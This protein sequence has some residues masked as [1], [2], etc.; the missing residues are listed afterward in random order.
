MAT[1]ST[2][3]PRRLVRCFLAASAATVL[4][5]AG[6]DR[7]DPLADVVEEA[8]VTLAALSGNGVSMPPAEVRTQ[9]YNRVITDLRDAL[10]QSGD[11]PGAGAARLIIAQAM[12]GQGDVAA[13]RS[14][15][16]RRDVE[17]TLT[18]ARSRLSLRLDRQVLGES[19]REY[20]P[21]QDLGRLDQAGE[22]TERE[23]TT[24]RASLQDRQNRVASLQEQ[25]DAELDAASGFREQEI[26]IREEARN[27]SP[28]Q[29]ARLIERAV[30]VKRNA[31]AHDRRAAELDLVVQSLEN[32]SAEIRIDI[33]SLLQQQQMN[34]EA[35]ERI[36]GASTLFERESSAAVTDAQNLASEIGGVFDAMIEALNTEV[37]PAFDEATGKYASA[38]SEAQQAASALS[39][40]NAAAAV[41]AM[42]RH[43]SA[44]LHRAHAATLGAL[45]S[46]ARKL[47]ESF[48]AGRF[49]DAAETLARERAE[50]EDQ[51][52]TL[53][54]TAASG[55]RG[56]RLSAGDSLD[57]LTSS[58]EDL[59]KAMRGEPDEPV[60][61]IGD[62][63][64]DQGTSPVDAPD[65]D[66]SD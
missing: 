46:F 23:L 31:D 51:A 17:R 6:C 55:Y 30:D 37:K 38:A 64:N 39:E 18:S 29:R 28:T 49:A 27:A 54:D 58:L 66:E 60:E 57:G 4:L 5:V 41:A 59:A 63:P 65:F 13:E 43:S 34:R 44:D 26:G 42:A 62:V 11:E 7:S 25:I 40:R 3:S 50:V 22:E 21:T 9:A 52:A 2:S 33:A 45:E 48:G 56:V 24:A 16:A 8:G 15:N 61:E 19:L 36:E 10:N 20:D 12:V 1:H 53:Y 35:R 32:E 47:G 14:G